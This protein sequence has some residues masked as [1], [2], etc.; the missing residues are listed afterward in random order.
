[1]QWADIEIYKMESYL[2]KYMSQIVSTATINH[3]TAQISIEVVSA[4]FS[5]KEL[6]HIDKATAFLLNLQK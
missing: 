4:I 2:D 1:M 5:K 6:E 3:F